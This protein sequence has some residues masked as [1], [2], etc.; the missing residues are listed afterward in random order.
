MM[1]GE[2]DNYHVSKGRGRGKNILRILLKLIS[3][4]AETPAEQKHLSQPKPSSNENI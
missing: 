3:I 2:M 1:E 4:S